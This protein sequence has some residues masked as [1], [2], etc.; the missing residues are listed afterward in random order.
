MTHG[1]LNPSRVGPFYACSG[2]GFLFS[3]IESGQAA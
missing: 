3:A 1:T 2:G